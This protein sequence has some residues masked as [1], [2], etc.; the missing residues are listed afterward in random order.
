MSKLDQS[1]DRFVKALETLE[2]AVH[3]RV[4]Q[5]GSDQ[6]LAEELVAM[7]DDRAQMAEEI[8]SLKSQNRSL[9]ELTDEVASRLD[10]AIGDIQTVLEQ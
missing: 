10:S 2:A 9:A 5:D 4:L 8:D 1:L 7:R 3:R 6:D